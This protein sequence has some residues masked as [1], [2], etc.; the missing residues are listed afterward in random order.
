MKCFRMRFKMF[1]APDH[2]I[3]AWFL[4]AWTAMKCAFSTRNGALKWTMT[5]VAKLRHQEHIFLTKKKARCK[6]TNSKKAK[7][8]TT[9]L[10][11]TRK[12]K[13]CSRENANTKW[14]K[15]TSRHF[16]SSTTIHIQS[17][18]WNLL[19]PQHENDIKETYFN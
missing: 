12:K 6:C 2:K 7:M 18:D 15:I 17:N 4:L 16:R 10:M 19:Q 13:L 8:T 3:L 5:H 1:H 9:T 11:M 14:T